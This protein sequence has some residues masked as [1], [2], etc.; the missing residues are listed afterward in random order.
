MVP[1]LGPDLEKCRAPIKANLALYIGGMGARDKNFYNSY[2]RNFSYEDLAT[3]LQDLYLSGQKNAAAVPNELVDAVALVGT[4][5]RIKD[6]LEQWK[7]SAVTTMLIGT[8]QP[9]ALRTLAELC[10]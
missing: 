6:Q 10:L 2:V 5:E 3:N 8:S 7:A 9:E 1:P 4:R